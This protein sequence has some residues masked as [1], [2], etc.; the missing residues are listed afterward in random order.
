ML[1][2]DVPRLLALAGNLDVD[3]RTRSILQ[4]LILWIVTRYLLVVLNQITLLIVYM[5]QTQT[6]HWYMLLQSLYGS[7]VLMSLIVRMPFLLFDPKLHLITMSECGRLWVGKW[8]MYTFSGHVNS[9]VCLRV[10]GILT[11]YYHNRLISRT[12]QAVGNTEPESVIMPMTFT[13]TFR[14]SQ[15]RTFSSLINTS[16]V[17]GSQAMH[18]PSLPNVVSIG[19]QATSN[20]LNLP[21]GWK[22]WRAGYPFRA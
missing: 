13:S 22:T 19:I 6:M 7:E 14:R 20:F 3:N 8:L 2:S 21:A 11:T 10:C 17:E 9:P 1:K 15:A 18:L 12:P 16:A 4:K 5:T